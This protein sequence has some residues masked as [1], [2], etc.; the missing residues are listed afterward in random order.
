VNKFRMCGHIAPCSI[1]YRLKT[2]RLELKGL[3][4]EVSDW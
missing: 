2:K 4:I 1:Q 3:Q